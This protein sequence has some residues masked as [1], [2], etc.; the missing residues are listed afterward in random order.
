MPSEMEAA[1]LAADDQRFEAMRK[2]NWPALEAS[3]A[4][5]LTYVHST[6]RLESKA[7]HV[8]NLKAGKPH[9]RG[10]APR[11]R[12]VR[13]RGEVGIVNG[14]SEM[15]VENAGKEQRFTVRYLAVYAKSGGAWRMIAWQSTRV[16]DA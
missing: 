7:E 6:A 5:E 10:I 8:S 1:V 13:V 15:H 2:E 14:I 16:P 9:Y 4:D 3:L 11:D 12:V